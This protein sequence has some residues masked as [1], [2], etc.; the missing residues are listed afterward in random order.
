[1][2]INLYVQ[3]N[4]RLEAHV[5]EKWIKHNI[6]LGVDHIYIYNNGLKSPILPIQKGKKKFSSPEKYN[7]NLSDEKILKIAEDIKNRYDSI[8]I[9]PWIYGEDHQ[10]PHPESQIKGFIDCVSNYGNEECW[11]LFIDP[12][13]FL[14]LNKHKSL[15]HFADDHKEYN[16]LKWGQVKRWETPNVY[17]WGGWKW[18]IK[19]AGINGIKQFDVRLTHRPKIFNQNK[20][21][22]KDPSVI[23]MNHLGT[24][25]TPTEKAFLNI[26]D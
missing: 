22:F 20:K 23:F 9:V 15:K 13:E 2:K 12:D 1:M 18:M 25:D 10:D 14:Y 4:L 3:V 7:Q 8:T 11:W 26:N 5:L 6:K 16:Y 19:I 21:E 24:P 17:E